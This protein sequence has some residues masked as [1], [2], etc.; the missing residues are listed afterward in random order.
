MLIEAEKI[1]PGL[2]D[3]TQT[4][5]ILTPA[6]FRKRINVDRHSFGGLAPVKGQKAPLCRTPI[7]GL[8]HIGC[9]NQWGGGVT[10]SMMGSRRAAKL[11]LGKELFK[12]IIK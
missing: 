10:G 11:I 9:Q 6:D 8:Y 3:R 12:K 7:N 4:R 5:V 2:R 1:I